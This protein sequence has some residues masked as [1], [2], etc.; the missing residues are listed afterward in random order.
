MTSVF[1]EKKPS[2]KS[3]PFF[4]YILIT[5]QLPMNTLVEKMLTKSQVWIYSMCCL[6]AF[7]SLIWCTSPCEL[8]GPHCPLDSGVAFYFQILL[9]L[10]F[11]YKHHPL[12]FL[13]LQG[14]VYLLVVSAV[15]RVAVLMQVHLR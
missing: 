12:P 6:R 2:I 13:L 10:L 8:Q 1:R 7:D 5:G 14:S 9:S 3:L 15:G 11:T 4:L